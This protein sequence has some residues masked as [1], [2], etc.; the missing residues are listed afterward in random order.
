MIAA[1]IEDHR[2]ARAM[3]D[4]MI[5]EQT[6]RK[7][8]EQ[9]VR[10]VVAWIGDH[11]GA[12]AMDDATIMEQTGRKARVLYVE[13]IGPAGRPFLIVTIAISREIVRSLARRSPLNPRRPSR[14]NPV[15]RRRW[16]GSFRKP[17][18]LRGPL[19][20]VGSMSAGSR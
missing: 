15:P 11:R 13:M 12:R 14:G 10:M 19:R 17:D 16:S 1:W 18:S 2:G 20:G 4:A 5:V 3:D 7:A 8:R 9:G 6:G